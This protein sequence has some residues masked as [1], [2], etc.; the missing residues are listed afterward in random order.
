MRKPHPTPV[1]TCAPAGKPGRQAVDRVALNAVYHPADAPLGGHP[2]QAAILSAGIFGT[3]LTIGLQ[4]PEMPV[5]IIRWSKTGTHILYV[6][7]HDLPPASR[8]CLS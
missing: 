4:A 3:H 7:A 6:T 8:N 5:N 1:S 2:V